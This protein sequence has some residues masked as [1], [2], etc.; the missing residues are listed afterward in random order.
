MNLRLWVAAQI[1][2]GA[3]DYAKE[4]TPLVVE[5]ATKMA[6]E[7]IKACGQDPDEELNLAWRKV[8][9]G[10]AVAAFERGAGGAFGAVNRCWAHNG[11]GK[12]CGAESI[13]IDLDSGIP[14]CEAHSAGRPRVLGAGMVDAADGGASG[15]QGWV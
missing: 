6:D 14:V 2:G 5:G 4:T 3:W 13:G 7:L 1:C 10:E 15:T 8:I 11:D 9:V 12:I